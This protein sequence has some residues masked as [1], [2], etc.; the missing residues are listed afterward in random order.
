MSSKLSSGVGCSS[1]KV[2]SG[3][4]GVVPATAVYAGGLEGSGSASGLLA[5]G[6]GS[7]ER[8]LY[9]GGSGAG[10]G[11]VADLVSRDLE[12]N[13]ATGKLVRAK[14]QRA[15]ACARGGGDRVRTC[16]QGRSCSA[17]STRCT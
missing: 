1:A 8:E 13:E 5:S 11:A 16:R 12:M 2:C 17:Q 6:V 7:C 3:C 10:V 14:C 15:H 4:A 9:A